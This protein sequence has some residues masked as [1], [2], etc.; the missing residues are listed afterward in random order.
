MFLPELRPDEVFSQMP[1]VLTMSGCFFL[2][3]RLADLSFLCVD[4]SGESWVRVKVDSWAA[5]PSPDILAVGGWPQLF[6]LKTLLLCNPWTAV[7]WT[8]LDPTLFIER[9]T[10]TQAINV[11]SWLKILERSFSE[12]L[13]DILT[14]QSQI[15]ESKTDDG[16]CILLDLIYMIYIWSMDRNSRTRLQIPLKTTLLIA[17]GLIDKSA[18]WEIN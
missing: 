5:R 8:H 4:G 15:H 3:R 17:W 6:C 10:Q 16:E 1:W 18:C 11:A 2:A 13:C 7:A 14:R 12:W 9:I